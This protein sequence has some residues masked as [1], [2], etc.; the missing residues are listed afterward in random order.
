M[1]GYLPLLI[2]ACLLAVLAA[3]AA[4][5][6][7]NEDT[8]IDD[9]SETNGT[10]AGI[11][12]VGADSPCNGDGVDDSAANGS[13][14]DGEMGVCVVGAGGPCNDEDPTPRDSA[15]ESDDGVSVGDRSGHGSGSEG[16]TD[17]GICVVG[18]GGPCNDAGAGESGR[19]GA[20]AGADSAGTG[21]GPVW[22]QQQSGNPFDALLSLLWSF[23]PAV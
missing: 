14:E 20:G 21:I 6:L 10:D 22:T 4:A 15:G 5:A 1:R 2:A 8:S 7:P 19:I 12:L 3:G 9:E 16:G 23:L 17:V 11:C 13:G 18:A